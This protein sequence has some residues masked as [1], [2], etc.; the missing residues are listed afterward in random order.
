MIIFQ[1]FFVE[2]SKDIEP[3]QL[4]NMTF[5]VSGIMDHQCNVEISVITVIHWHYIYH[6]YQE[7]VSGSDD[8]AIDNH[9]CQ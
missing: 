5:Y 7:Y 9:Q 1:Y 8:S 4:L 2:I 3:T 6:I